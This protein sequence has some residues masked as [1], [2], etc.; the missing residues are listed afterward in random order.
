MYWEINIY[1]NYKSYDIITNG[2]FKYINC[3]CN[4]MISSKPLNGFGFYNVDISAIAENAER[5]KNY[6]FVNIT[7]YLVK[8]L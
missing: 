4:K 6:F 3:S 7:K 8:L 5:I 1:N 2:T